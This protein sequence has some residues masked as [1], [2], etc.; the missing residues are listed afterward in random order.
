VA[1]INPIKAAWDELVENG[2]ARE[3]A[4]YV[5]VAE[6][7]TSL[8]LTTKN[9]NDRYGRNVEEAVFNALKFSEPLRQAT[10]HTNSAAGTKHWHER[11]L[12]ISW[13]YHP[14]LGLNLSVL[15]QR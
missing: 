13:H 9:G 7:F 8:F 11:G 1:V 14:D 12:E 6:D 15:I 2:Y 4:E 3:N 10:A 5:F